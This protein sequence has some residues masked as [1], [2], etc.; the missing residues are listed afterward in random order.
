MNTLPKSGI[1]LI[2]LLL[3][4]AVIWVF[5]VLQQLLVPLFFAVLFA[6]LLYPGAK[7]MEG[8]GVP[9]V[10]TN[11]ILIIS[12]IGIIVGAFYTIGYF[13]SN[14]AEDFSDIREQF[15]K[16]MSYFRD[17]V[18]NLTG[19]DLD[20][21]QEQINEFE[22]A[23]EY[24]LEF[25][26]ATTNTVVAIGLMPVYTFLLLLYRN[27][28]RT[29]VDKLSSPESEKTVNS[30]VDSAAE[31]VPKYLKGLIVVVLILMVV[32]S[33]VFWLIGLE[34][35]IVYGI[36]A[37]LFNLIPYLGTII[38][39]AVVL[40]FVLATQAPALALGVIIAFFPI[41]F[42]ENN[43]LTPNITGSYVQINPLIIILS[44]FAG[45]MMWGLA[46]M[47]LVIPYLALA[48]IVCENID[49]LKPI[50]YLIGTRGTEEHFPS[51]ERLKVR[52]RNLFAGH[53]GS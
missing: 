48:K 44:L 11:L 26:T 17:T 50:A 20:K 42:F 25:F 18:F 10:I 23:S 22:G 32:N 12:A 9:R 21:V 33:T 2:R 37:A 28:F 5:I 13:F 35:P 27:K 31:I 24:F 49:S 41:Q 45:N 8:K 39:F 38:G 19:F 14:F 1:Y 47:L 4:I 29:F 34:Y 52:M 51:I 40:I 7:F 36:I 43:I 16:N 3:A 6:Y 53:K 30:I 46:G 15:E